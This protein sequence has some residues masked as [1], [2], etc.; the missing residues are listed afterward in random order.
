MKKEALSD[1]AVL[2]LRIGLAIVFVYFGVDKFLN[3]QGNAEIISS[4]GVPINAIFFTIFYGIVEVVVGSFLILG[5]FTRITAG[6]AA[7]MLTVTLLSFWIKLSIFI[8]R[9]VGLLAIAVFLMLNSGGRIGLDKYIRVK[10]I[11]EQ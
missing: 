3:L 6:V 11:F 8:P 4:I 5:L 9:D 1:I 2:V 10:G 7:A